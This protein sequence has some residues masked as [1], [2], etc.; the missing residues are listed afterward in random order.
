MNIVNAALLGASNAD[1]I[2][3]EGK[4]NKKDGCWEWTHGVFDDGYGAFWVNG[5]TV[6]AH[7]FSYFHHKGEYDTSLLVCHTCDNPLCVNPDHL[8]LGTPQDNSTDMVEKGR[9]A[10]N[11]G[12]KS[13]T[14]FANRA[15]GMRLPQTKLTDSQVEEIRKR[16][17]AGGVLQRELA[18]EYGTTQCNI[19]LIV[20]GM[21]RVE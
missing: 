9:A 16:Y 10:S 15:R 3:F 8:F 19:S 12:P 5:Q 7:R 17:S 1:R 2:R 13:P 20:R 6:K 11:K 4:L 18:D 14:A 21:S